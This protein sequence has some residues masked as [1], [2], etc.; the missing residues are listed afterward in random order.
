[1][2]WGV[3]MARKGG[4]PAERV[5]NAMPLPQILAHLAKRKRAFKR[6]EMPGRAPVRAAAGH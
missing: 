1:M 2:H 3:E 6:K 5:L 4:I